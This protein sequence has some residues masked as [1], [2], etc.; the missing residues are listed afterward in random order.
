MKKNRYLSLGIMSGT[1]N[2]GI[3]L[4]LIQS[5]G[6]SKFDVLSSKYIKYNSDLV[7]DL[8]DLTNNIN[9]LSIYSSRIIQI[10]DRVTKSYIG[11][12]KKF[13]KSNHSKIDLISLHGQTI[14]HDPYKKISIQ[15][16]NAE[17]IKSE[18]NS[19]IV[20][21]FRQ[22]DL[23]YGGQGAPLVPVFHKL[24]NNNLS[25]SGTNAFLNIGGVSNITII[26]N[27]KIISAFDVGP[28]MA[29]LNDYVFHKKKKFY[30]KNGADSSRGKIN[31]NLI[32]SLMKDNF[33]KKDPPKSLDKNYFNKS[34]FLKLPYYDACASIVEFTAE[35]IKRSMMFSKSRV[36]NLICMGG[37]VKNDH[38]MRRIKDKI[39]TNTLRAKDLGIDEDFIEAQAFAYLGIRR[40]KKLPITYPQTTG[41]AK[42]TIGGKVI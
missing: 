1:S 26:E 20:Y 39:N 21:D 4:S 34:R 8:N 9:K 15:L 25:L 22:N 30:D 11:A 3:D 42:A 13:N 7:E 29:I 5:D 17:L 27:N 16:C 35:C 31:K 12:I 37:G 2:D 32:I 23:K 40:L 24:M 18:F 28:G 38:L 6:I 36:D 41:V 33:F 19:H 14:F 10:Q